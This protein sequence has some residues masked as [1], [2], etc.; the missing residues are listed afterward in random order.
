MVAVQ[1]S[2]G[3]ETEP[4]MVIRG[5]HRGRMPAGPPGPGWVTWHDGPGGTVIWTF[6]PDVFDG[7][8][9]PPACLPTLTI[10]RERHRGPRGRPAEPGSNRAWTV[11][12]RLEPEVMI[13]RVRHDERDVA[14]ARARDLAAAFAADEL[15]YRGAYLQ[16]R[17]DYLAVLDAVLPVEEP[18]ARHFSARQGNGRR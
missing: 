4:L 18:E 1:I 9:L 7:E 14:I 2:H 15:D 5:E 16:P 6:R 13:E 11:E 17:D 8:R 10:K 3:A 12:L